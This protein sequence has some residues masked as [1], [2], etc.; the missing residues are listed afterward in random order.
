VSKACPLFLVFPGTS[1]TPLLP[2]SSA[3]SRDR[4]PSSNRFRIAAYLDPQV[5]LQGTWGCDRAS[6]QSLQHE[7]SQA[8]RRPGASQPP[9]E[10]GFRGGL[11]PEQGSPELYQNKQVEAALKRPT[12]TS[13]NERRQTKGGSSKGNGLPPDPLTT[14]RAGQPR[15]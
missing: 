1:S 10:S 13:G 8:P 15:P 12:Q 7:L 9:T 11:R 4:A 2:P 6:C 14:I 5:G 3:G